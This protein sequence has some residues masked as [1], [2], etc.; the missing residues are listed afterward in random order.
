MPS[1][2]GKTVS[3]LSLIISYQ[4]RHAEVSKLVYCSR[5][6]PEMEKV[7]EEMK[8]VVQYVREQVVAEEDLQLRMSLD[9][10]R[11]LG[12]SLSSR[13][14]L[15]CHP[16]VAHSGSGEDVDGACRALT[17]G[18]VRSKAKHSS[19]VE[20]CSFYEKYEEMRENI[21]IS[22]GIY[23]LGDLKEYAESQQMCPYFL[24]RS[25]I[26]LASI[27]VYN[28]QYLLDPK[29]SAIVS[30]TLPANAVVVFDEAHNIDSVCIESLSCW[31]DKGILD[32]ST[33]NIVQ[34][35]SQVSELKATNSSRLNDEYRALIRGLS[36]SNAPSQSDD[37]ISDGPPLQLSREL[38]DDVVPGNIRRAEHFLAF[39][40]RVCE[41]LKLRLKGESASVES[42]LSFVQNLA[43]T[44]MVNANALKYTESR[45][46]S[47]LRTLEIASS[48]T[49]YPLNVLCTFC[50][51]CSGSN[52]GWSVI[53]EPAATGIA[54]DGRLTVQCLDAS[55][56][57]KPV[58]SKF[59]SVILTSGTLSPLDMYP[60]LLGF[61]ALYHKSLPMTLS[62][63]CLMPVIVTRGNDQGSL[64]S[65]FKERGQREVIA[66][67]GRLLAELCAVVPDG[68]AGFFPSY[69]YLETAV[70]AWIDM[71]ILQSVTRHKLLF[72][73]TTDVS[74]T[75]LAL[76]H[77]R[78]AVACGRGAVFLCVAR[79]KVSE[80]IDFE[81]PFGRCVILFGI[82]Y[83]YTESLALRSRLEY[84]NRVY[85]IKEQ[86]F[87]AFDAIR[88]ASQCL[89]RAIRNKSDY[90]VM[91]LADR[92]YSFRSKYEKLPSWI[93]RHLKHNDLS[94][95]QVVAVTK[96]FLRDMAQPLER[97][98][99]LG[100][101]LLSAAQVDVL[102]KKHVNL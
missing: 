47:L 2:T 26:S 92:R 29:I 55:L 7:M 49:F 77:Y 40:L 38:L 4:I 52:S 35:K 51:L 46:N 10:I 6:V 43:S 44:A 48:A 73:E 56:A 101:A 31:L 41:Y 69:A 34:L 30:S 65:G 88:H 91:V 71:G 98:N 64:S 22:D 24:A 16:T 72:I 23:S 67:Y 58:F 90:G 74:E 79:G 21:T 33:G 37:H 5:T 70:S 89:G 28:Y 100:T 87:L 78:A 1:G 95:D 42:P 102:E 80:G 83:V 18:W 53:M 50:V 14:N 63:P 17:A 45:L 96:V 27:V 20:L 60:K 86:D 93:L 11:I 75:V 12:L 13:K 97:R 84:L 57:L 66:N 82:P 39:M 94:V 59:R 15:C 54:G 61:T 81:G 8:V 99:L 36:A 62:R 76:S 68:V 32:K 3:L 85:N 25:V 19:E 9:D